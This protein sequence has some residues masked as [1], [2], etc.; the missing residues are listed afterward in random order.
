MSLPKLSIAPG[1][2]TT[3]AYNEVNTLLSLES[4]LPDLDVEHH[5]SVLNTVWA[6]I[7]NLTAPFF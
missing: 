2:S 1:S 3:Q 7:L 4:P 6:D 5:F